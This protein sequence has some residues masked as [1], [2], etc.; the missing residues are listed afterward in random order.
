MY[1]LIQKSALWLAAFILAIGMYGCS[2]DVMLEPTAPTLSSTVLDLETI[3]PISTQTVN[4]PTQTLAALTTEPLDAPASEPPPQDAQQNVMDPASATPTEIAEPELDRFARALMTG[5]S[6]DIVGVYVENV[7]A[8][9]VVQQVEGDPAFV[10]SQ[11]GVS[12]EFLL[13]FRVAGNIGLL[14]HNYLAGALFFELQ[15]GHIIYIIYGDGEM[16]EFEV[17]RIERFQALDPYN[18]SSD[19]THIENNNK[20]NATELFNSMYAGEY[21]LTMQTC[22]EKDG[23]NVWGRIFIISP[24]Y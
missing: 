5:Q 12:T 7:L 2:S 23:N 15:P 13:A 10:S 6:D 16:E 21:H 20:L 4:I 8:L 14:A 9:R 3:T 1:C 22:I 19:F 24:P 18:P 11:P 17:T